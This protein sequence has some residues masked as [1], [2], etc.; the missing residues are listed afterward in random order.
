MIGRGHEGRAASN[1]SRDGGEDDAA[2]SDAEPESMNLNL[3]ENGSTWKGLFSPESLPL[4]C[5]LLLDGQGITC[6]LF[7]QV[8]EAGA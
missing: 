1:E 2:P 6:N 4:L 5:D 3:V 7:V 8:M